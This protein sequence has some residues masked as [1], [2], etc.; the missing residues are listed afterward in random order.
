M[1]FKVGQKVEL[2]DN[3]SMT[4]QKGATAIVEK[5]FTWYGVSLIKVT[6]K[7]DFGYQ[8]NGGYESFR[9]KPLLRKNEQLLFSFMKD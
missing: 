9:F 1:S 4:A 8:M 2:V 5:L 3:S 7:T 6:W